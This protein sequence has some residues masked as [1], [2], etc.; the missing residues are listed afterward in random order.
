ME[1][2]ELTVHTS[3]VASELVADVM[4]N[5]T[6]LGVAI[7]DVNDV[8]ELSKMKRKMWDYIEDGLLESK[9]VLVKGYFELGDKDGIKNVLN[10]LAELKRN[11]EF[12]V[13]S[14]ETITRTV[15]GDA[16]LVT[17]K[18]HFKP[19]HIGKVVI[20]PEWIKY[21][22]EDG[23]TVVKIDA[24]MAFG[25]GEHETTSMCI[26][27]LQE[28][29]QK[30]KSVIDV[31]CGSGILGI[32]A[33]NLGCKDVLMTDIDANAVEASKHNARLNGVTATIIEKNLLDDTSVK[34]DL[35]LANIVA[36]VLIAFAKDIGNNL[37]E[38]GRIILSGILNEKADAVITAYRE[39]GFKLLKKVSKGEWTAVCMGLG[40]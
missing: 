11:S 21:N 28:F 5:Y 30:D 23:E 36:E 6:N 37:N 8:I 24:N 16:W 40:E 3:S 22:A 38:N 2:S 15:D 12:N 34:G 26:E 35:I 20:C 27:L 25:T 31:G 29:M 7:S 32:T 19:L 4:W 18:E 13:G 9:D 1:Y 39:N 17:W 14:L 10:E 33:S